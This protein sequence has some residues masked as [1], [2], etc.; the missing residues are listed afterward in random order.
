MA[1]EPRRTLGERMDER[2][3]A[4]RAPHRAR[5]HVSSFFS[6]FGLADPLDIS[7]RTE[8]G[9]PKADAVFAM[10]RR[11]GAA[12]DRRNTR[13]SRLF[14]RDA[15][16]PFRRFGGEKARA[17]APFALSS[18]GSGDFLLIRPSTQEPAQ[19]V[20]MTEQPVRRVPT[21]RPRLLGREPRV[22]TSRAVRQA[23]S[24]PPK[25]KK[26]PRL[27][28]MDV[29][30]SVVRKSRIQDAD[31]TLPRATRRESSSSLASALPV[32]RS[33]ERVAASVSE[34]AKAAVV[35]RLA[36]ELRHT[37]R[38]S[39]NGRIRE[40]LR[41]IGASDDVLVAEVEASLPDTYVSPVT[42]AMSRVGE[43]P[44]RGLKPVTR[45]SP[46][47][48]AATGG[49]S[50]PATR[51]V[52][53]NVAAA[54]RRAKTRTARALPRLTGAPRR[55]PSAGS[56]S[57]SAGEAGSEGPE[58][59]AVEPRRV[60]LEAARFEVEQELD[61][62]SPADEV[63]RF[64]SQERRSTR[65]RSI[66]RHA[67]RIPA[68]AR[69]IS[70]AS[71][72]GFSGQR[73]AD[74][75]R[76]SRKPRRQQ[77]VSQA[78]VAGSAPPVDAPR[79]GLIGRV[80]QR[81]ERSA[82]VGLRPE[83][84]DRLGMPAPKPGLEAAVSEQEQ[85][86]TRA[87]PSR[88]ERLA[89][90]RVRRDAREQAFEAAHSGP[91]AEAVRRRWPGE[92]VGRAASMPTLAPS[93]LLLPRAA[94]TET[95]AVEASQTQPT[96]Q[97]S[98]RTRAMAAV[99]GRSRPVAR[100]TARNVV[101]SPARASAARA[102][103]SLPG[104][105]SVAAA[106]RG[107]GAAR[108]ADRSEQVSPPT[109]AM[110]R[111]AEIASSV[112]ALVE[113]AESFDGS[114]SD[115]PR[116]RRVDADSR[117]EVPVRAMDRAGQR[118]QAQVSEQPATRALRDAAISAPSARAVARV[119]QAIE[120]ISAETSDPRERAVVVRRALRE[121]GPAGRAI[122]AEVEAALPAAS[123]RPETVARARI[124][125]AETRGTLGL[126]PV[127]QRSPA[128]V[129]LT[130]PAISASAEVAEASARP[131][132]RAAVAASAR[133]SLPRAARISASPVSRAPGASSKLSSGT[134]SASPVRRETTSRVRTALAPASSA[135]VPAVGSRP[136]SARAAS[137]VSG[138][139]AVESTRRIDA[140]GAKTLTSGRVASAVVADSELAFGSDPGDS[141]VASARPSARVMSRLVAES[142]SVDA[143]SSAPRPRRAS[144]RPGAAVLSGGRFQPAASADPASAGASAA[145]VSSA[146]HA[147]SR[148]S[149]EEPARSVLPKIAPS[150]E[151]ALRRS[152]ARALGGFAPEQSLIRP[153][154]GVSSAVAEEAAASPVGRAA[155]RPRGDA[156]RGS[157]AQP[158]GVTPR[159]P[160][161]EAAF[162]AGRA[163]AARAGRFVPVRELR[164]VDGGAS[165]DAERAPVGSQIG[166]VLRASSR[167]EAGEERASSL[168]PGVT[169][170]LSSPAR[171]Q[172][173]RALALTG[174]I[175][176]PTPA[177][178]SSERLADEGSSAVGARAPRLAA[179]AA[180]RA[181]ARG[182]L[183]ELRGSLM[184]ATTPRH[185]A[186]LQ[187]RVASRAALPLAFSGVGSGSG[188]GGA[189]FGGA[190][191][192]AGASSRSDAGSAPSSRELG[193]RAVVGARADANSSAG[194]ASARTPL[195]AASRGSARPR[196]P[197][198]YVSAP[199][200][201]FARA[202]AEISEVAAE[203]TASGRALDRTKA[204]NAALARAP[205][206]ATLGRLQQP[207]SATTGVV[208][209]L[210]EARAVE[211]VLAALSRGPS[212]RDAR[213]QR[214]SAGARKL[215]G[216]VLVE[217]SQPGVSGVSASSRAALTEVHSLLSGM[218]P[219]ESAL[220]R[221]ARVVPGRTRRM[222]VSSPDLRLPE[223]ASAASSPT[224]EGAAPARAGTR[225]RLS[226]IRALAGT[227]APSDRAERAAEGRNARTRRSRLEPRQRLS[228][229]TSTAE[230]VFA[231]PEGAP[232][233]SGGRGGL[234]DTLGAVGTGELGPDLPGWAH[235]S[236]GET[237][238]RGTVGGLMDAL[239]RARSPD[240]VVRAMDRREASVR[241]NR[242]L[243]A[244]V[245]RLIEEIRSEAASEAEAS[246]AEMAAAMGLPTPVA[247]R[248]RGSTRQ[249]TSS[250]VFRGFTNLG[251]TKRTEGQDGLGADRL[252]KLVRKLQQLVFLADSQRDAAMRQVRLA[253]DS[254]SAR[255]EGQAAP[256]QSGDA[257]NQQVDV[258]ALAQEVAQ[259]VQRELE[260]RSERR[261]DDPDNRTPWW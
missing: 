35:R 209:L 33:L 137:P 64:S 233:G 38:S 227:P 84:Y 128:L 259:H 153:D 74:E 225:T 11:L 62:A 19:T 131:A 60:R 260:S 213:V 76:I 143:T 130:A 180:V 243:P 113:V 188:L 226:Q 256:T 22:K 89:A 255:S 92:R 18:F 192:Q 222:S 85:A 221:A 238:V 23:L 27:P 237:R 252:M 49:E 199:D 32:L 174:E 257:K 211:E 119:V 26:A 156:E 30:P 171:G 214:V 165:A 44:E 239:A 224:A 187:A 73:W 104:S 184:P 247:S 53:K 75:A 98:S 230:S 253:E 42:M 139:P 138:G 124:G 16:A 97:P 228:A 21:R 202:A 147:F 162:R 39:W 193:S 196:G 134:L 219:E 148:L 46:L 57:A 142:S 250:Q 102:V 125:A 95:E 43:Q 80:T 140:E 65:A 58:A 172:T 150:A 51:H 200:T 68:S 245:L 242:T 87:A 20:D 208:R 179:S 29:R 191:A 109:P 176:L 170:R 94:V 220:A 121:L 248:R 201:I 116:S 210:S 24:S 167:G 72:G 158:R 59:P 55:G 157:P 50:R 163:E 144:A 127:L 135:A 185:A 217:A 234:T 78:T 99:L 145:G 181:S 249:T 28:T 261:Q 141:R 79:T 61:L 146:V 45:S 3:K 169:P 13:F 69:A 194:R 106:P 63:S 152:V 173:R 54:P 36:A 164:A 77:V 206:G 203:P 215:L 88:L 197:L 151:A 2:M 12:E 160:S 8:A 117:A 161:V 154:S 212:R 7:A 251:Q 244:P 5:T 1:G 223:Q 132:A 190:A 149:L 166:A 216:E 118:L 189:S 81:D 122:A 112:R 120:A 91:R 229:R 14:G 218:V 82:A 9:A 103:A 240:E 105:R 175:V 17:L 93:D 100:E 114:L 108:R 207:A 110:V 155:S 168:L 246:A 86:E 31:P 254:A 198:S 236:V 15:S 205:Q 37:P 40:T 235:R 136:T 258:E 183:N 107:P 177:L 41:Q 133:S 70:R 67:G 111:G 178:A 182:E 231:R 123:A 10:L 204:R 195:S 25:A 90:S 101:S 159:A 232:A 126:R 71:S 96:R 56:V 52:R 47:V 48:R 66:T 6:R 4:R 241:S 115:S 186:S 129:E 34:P 83:F